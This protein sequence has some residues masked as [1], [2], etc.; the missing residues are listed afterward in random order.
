ME[1]L[2][3]DVNV[4]EKR[5]IFQRRHFSFRHRLVSR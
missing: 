4:K 1:K 5:R 2:K 3:R